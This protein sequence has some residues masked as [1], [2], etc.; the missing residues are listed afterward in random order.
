[1][2]KIKLRKYPGP[3]WIHLFQLY[4][5][6]DMEAPERWDDENPEKQKQAIS[7][8]RRLW[9]A[10]LTRPPFQKF[11]YQGKLEPVEG[12]NSYFKSTV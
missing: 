2:A 5:E 1:M 3:V 9:R 12:G 4:N 10:A 8:R 7:S 6:G 11:A